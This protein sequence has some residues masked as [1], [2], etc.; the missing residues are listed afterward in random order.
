MIN[1]RIFRLIP[2]F[3]AGFVSAISFFV[4]WLKFKAEGVSLETGLRIGRVIFIALN[5][6]KWIF[7]F[8]LLGLVF[9]EKR[10]R[11]RHLT[12]KEF[13]ILTVS[14]ILAIQTFWLLPVLVDRADKIILGTKLQP[15]SEHLIFGIL[16]LMKVSSLLLLALKYEIVHEKE[17]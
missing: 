4:A 6:M 2:A 17:N 10:F 8:A 7:L 15:S 1:N 12:K 3:W 9:L 16:E 13:P 11:V 14:L 5:R